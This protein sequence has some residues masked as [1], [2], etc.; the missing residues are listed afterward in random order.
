MVNVTIYSIH[1]SYGLTVTAY[2]AIKL[3]QLSYLGAP[4]C[5][6]LPYVTHTFSANWD[7]VVLHV[8]G[9]HIGGGGSLGCGKFWTLS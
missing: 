5:S 6:D 1:G 7:G 9:P 8:W 2:L 3:K 4:S